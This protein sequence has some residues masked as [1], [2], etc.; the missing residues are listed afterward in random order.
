[1]KVPDGFH[2]RLIHPNPPWGRT[3]KA[4]PMQDGFCTASIQDKESSIMVFLGVICMRS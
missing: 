2:W 4:I 3:K 1:M